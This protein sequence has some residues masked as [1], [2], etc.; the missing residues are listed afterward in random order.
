MS[1]YSPYCTI[2]DKDKIIK[3]LLQVI[4]TISN[5]EAKLYLSDAIRLSKINTELKELGIDLK[6]HL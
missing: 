1:S 6:K 5:P 3:L 4:E 2:M